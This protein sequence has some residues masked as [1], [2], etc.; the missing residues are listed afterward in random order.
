MG[1]GVVKFLIEDRARGAAPHVTPRDTQVRG[2]PY[3]QLHSPAVIVIIIVIVVV[4]EIIV[5]IALL[6]RLTLGTPLQS[7]GV[8]PAAAAGIG[9]RGEG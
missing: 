9:G 5:V 2:P 4:V 7:L 6:L 1:Q 3:P 8:T